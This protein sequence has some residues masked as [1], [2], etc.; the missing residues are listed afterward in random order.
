[1]NELAVSLGRLLCLAG[2]HVGVPAPR[3]YDIAGLQG[4]GFVVLAGAAILIGWAALS[5]AHR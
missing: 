4:V 2:T 3:C 5:A 1:M